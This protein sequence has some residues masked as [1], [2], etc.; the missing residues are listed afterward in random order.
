MHLLMVAGSLS[1]GVI[2]RSAGRAGKARDLDGLVR[3]G[4]GTRAPG[5]IKCMG[6]PWPPPWVQ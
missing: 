2:S 4:T 3:P 6:V 1:L 5:V